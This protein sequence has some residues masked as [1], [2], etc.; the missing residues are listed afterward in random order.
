[1]E[2]DLTE[3]YLKANANRDF[4]CSQFTEVV[5]DLL[6][7]IGASSNPALAVDRAADQ[8]RLVTK[9]LTYADD[10][11]TIRDLFAHA[12]SDLG[13]IEGRTA[14]KQDIVD[15]ALRGVSLVAEYSCEDRAA[16]ARALKREEEFV[17]AANNISSSK[18]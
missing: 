4:I 6:R 3:A 2:E 8:M 16:R 9:L 18:G 7:A 15:A 1:M 13:E 10:Q 5:R 17:A 14:R 12:A 11:L